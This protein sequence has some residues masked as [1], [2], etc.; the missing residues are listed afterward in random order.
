MA[1]NQK[2]VDTADICITNLA[3]TSG[4]TFRTVEMAK[5]KGMQIYYIKGNTYE[6][7]TPTNA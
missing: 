6:S 2:M 5:R 4:G 7:N 3:E 1:R